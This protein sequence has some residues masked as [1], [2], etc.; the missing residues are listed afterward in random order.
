VI[1]PT[2]AV[3]L[4]MLAI[5]IGLGSLPHAFAQ[6]STPVGDDAPREVVKKSQKIDFLYHASEAYLAAG[7]SFDMMTTANGLGHPTT[8]WTNNGVFLTHYYVQ[9]KGWARIAGRRDTAGVVLANVV[10]NAGIDLLDRKL[11][12][13]GGKWR[14]VAVGLNVLKGTGNFAAGINNMRTLNGIDKVVQMQ[15]GYR[16]AV[17]WSR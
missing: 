1:F 16:G 15:T 10:L 9:E 14:T 4:I 8:A 2:K 13:R 12:R 6:T 3:V 17:V 7:T 11:Y 5:A